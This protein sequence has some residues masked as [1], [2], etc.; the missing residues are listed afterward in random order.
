M[1]LRG[2]DLEEDGEQKQ[3]GKDTGA[4]EVAEVQRHGER[5]AAGFA[6]CGG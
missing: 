1:K 6:E 5:V 4:D 2:F 3:S